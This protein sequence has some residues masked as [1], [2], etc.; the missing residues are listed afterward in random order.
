MDVAII[1]LL[2]GVVGILAVS[3]FFTTIVAIFCNKICRNEKG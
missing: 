2:V 1:G 3:V